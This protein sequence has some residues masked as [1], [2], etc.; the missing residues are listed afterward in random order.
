MKLQ[1][2]LVVVCLLSCSKSESVE[3][4]P[5]HVTDISEATVVATAPAQP[6]VVLAP[7][8]II[9]AKSSYAEAWAYAAP[10]MTDTVNSPS[11]GA[12]LFTIWASKYLKW[13]DISVVRNET[14]FAKVS[15][16]PDAERGKRLCTLSRIIEIQRVPTDN[17]PSPVFIGGAFMNGGFHNVARFFAVKSTGDL[18]QNSSARFCGVVVGKVSYMN[19]VGG[20]THA[21]SLVG[22]FDLPENH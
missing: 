5:D 14:T 3:K 21:L 11:D 6:P 20:T 16:D 8:Q 10:G 1:S 15:K 7:G 9:M 17:T 2:V 22:M 12:F 19:S 4:S 18:V 13:S